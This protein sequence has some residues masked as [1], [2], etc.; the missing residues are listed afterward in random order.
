MV[1]LIAIGVSSGYAEEPFRIFTGTDG[2]AIEARIVA[3]NIREGT[4][5]VERKNKRKITVESTVFSTA[6]QAYIKEWSSAQDFLSSSKF[7]ISIDKKSGKRGNNKS[8]TKKP[9]APAFF[10]IQFQNRSDT[11][12]K[13]LR[14]EYQILVSNEKNE[15]IAR[16]SGT[17]DKLDLLPKGK[18]MIKTDEVKT[19][20]HYEQQT[21]SNY[22]YSG[23]ITRSVSYNKVDEETVE[24][25]MV[26]VYLKTKSGNEF[27]REIQQP[28][29]IGKKYT[30][31]R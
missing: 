6:D 1:I 8:Q 31:S 18:K 28:D 27:V 23:Y 9:K 29:S 14:V 12:F 22:D 16:T 20:R 19:Y 10:E 4:V 21:E 24:G 5:T 13:E 2:R 11:P 25:V 15:K 30:W 3:C 26:R 7:K 17:A